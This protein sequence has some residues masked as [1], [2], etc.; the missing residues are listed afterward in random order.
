MR[1]PVCRLRRT[2]FILAIPDDIR[3]ILF[4]FR[5]KPIIWWN[6]PVMMLRTVFLA[7]GLLMTGMVHAQL[8]QLFVAVNGNDAAPGTLQ[9]PLKTI[10][11]ALA[12]ATSYPQ[13]AVL[14]RA[15]TYY[16]DTTLL[17]NRSN[18]TI[19]AWKQEAVTISAG[20][21]LQLQW[22][23]YRNGIWQARVPSGITFESLFING[24]QQ[25]RARYPDY[26]STARVYHGT[27]ADAIA[28]ERVQR[29]KN[30]AGGY[31]HALHAGEWGS[32]D[33][34]ITGKGA[35]TLQLE[36]GWQN[37]R[38]SRMH[39]QFRFVENIFEELDKAGEWYLDR[40]QHILYFYPPA[41]LRLPAAVVE[42]DHLREAVV[43][44]GSEA[45]PLHRVEIAGIRFQHTTP[46]FMDTREPL[47]RS[48]WCIYRGGAILLEG[49]TGSV[50]RDC[51]FTQL[52]G[53]AIFF[54]NYNKA[55]TVSGCKVAHIGASAVCF[56]GDPAAVRSPA[57]RYEDHVPYAQLD[58]TPGPK[59]NNFPQACVVTNN[60]FHDLGGIE[61]QATGVQI[62]MSSG[63]IVTHNTIYNTPRAGI[64]I[65]DG[66]WGGHEI[67]Y[68]DVFNTVLETGD[69]GAFNSWGRDRFWAADRRYMDSLVAAQPSL[70]LLDVVQPVSIHHNRFRC[71]HGWD[72]D[73]DDGS[74]NYII[75]HNV[76]LNGGLK[77]REGFNR[78]VYNNIILNNSFHPHVWF[79]N[80][81][82]VF[83]HNVVMKKYFPIQ[84]TAWGSRV[85]SNY[86]MDD[87]ALQAAR[88][89]GTD[90]HSE[91]ITL[92][93]AD[94]AK[95]DYRLLHPPAGFHNFPMTFGVQSAVLRRQAMPVP[96][97]VLR[98]TPDKKDAAAPVAFLGGM[99]KSVS[100]LGERSAYGLADEAGVIIM[101]AAGSKLLTASRLQEKDVITEAEGKKIK[102]VQSLLDLLQESSWKGKIPI[103][104][105]RNQQL[106]EG[107]LSLK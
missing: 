3:L 76:C 81:G 46:T 96:L 65:G 21:R 31:V 82:D 93:F 52:G 20:R 75:H 7:V 10:P 79:K 98:L 97:P 106:L 95:G 87:A 74:G 8:K 54:S 101:A 1:N 36:G 66:C 49:T 84:V 105:I 39:P 2:G 78:T 35:D 107:V 25:V 37:N 41:A 6:N 12:K 9:Q 68:N 72:I 22:Q 102:D 91:V 28:P 80:S 69:H 33:Y 42:T 51:I 55:D 15:G 38:P 99:I 94:A 104:I 23:P 29:W 57:F 19:S 32:F 63:I 43:I 90:A 13:A 86:F 44:Q 88:L 16:L 103:K 77:L 59:G 89:N 48:D 61:K 64:N 53:N 70:I 85:D 58:L 47:L 5:M 17:I 4:K 24:Q 83:T 67:A 62:A 73:L 27:A 26:D 18:L 11:A 14:L 100:G 40:H 71:D 34:R 50:I 60:L 92:R 45:K 56:T 30:P